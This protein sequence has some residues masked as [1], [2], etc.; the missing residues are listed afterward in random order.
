MKMRIALLSGLVT[1]VASAAAAIPTTDKEPAT[2]PARGLFVWDEGLTAE[3]ATFAVQPESTELAVYSPCGC[4]PRPGLPFPF[5]FPLPW[6][7]TGPIF[8]P[9]PIPGPC[10][11]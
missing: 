7:P 11:F 9:F 3:L 4:T 8:D 2:E 6:P 1:L 5:P 10:P